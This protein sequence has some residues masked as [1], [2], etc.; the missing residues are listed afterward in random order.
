M[1]IQKQRQYALAGSA[2]L[3]NVLSRLD[4]AKPRGKNKWLACCPAHND[5]SP[6][7]ALTETSDGT[8]LLKCW[9]G[10]TAKDIVTAIGLELRDL[11]PGEKRKRRAPSAAAVN[12][13]RAI[14]LIGKSELD[15]GKLS[16]D[17]LERFN[18][19]KKRLGVE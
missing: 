13:E 8:I 19:A 5:K 9:A 2:C 1:T 11:F 10:C 15:A 7:L 6:S 4:K 16:G 17:D 14:Y 3:D 18:L 12:H